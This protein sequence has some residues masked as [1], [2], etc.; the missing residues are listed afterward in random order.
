MIATVFDRVR[1]RLEAQEARSA[2]LKSEE[3]LPTDFSIINGAN[4]QVNTPDTETPP[5]LSSSQDGK[6][7]E[8]LTLQSFENNKNLDDSLADSAPTTVTRARERKAMR[9]GSGSVSRNSLQEDREEGELSIEDEDEIYI[10]DAFLV[11]RSLCKLSQK[12][13][14]YDQQQDLKS[15]NMR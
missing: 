8:K 1:V 11:F 14:T 13:L 4:S 10:K 3:T 6:G 15:Q 5:T 9:A 2:S 12:V 7:Q